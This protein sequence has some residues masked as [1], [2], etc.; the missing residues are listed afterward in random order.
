MRYALAL[1]VVLALL[2]CVLWVLALRE[3]EAVDAR[4]N[5]A[6]NTVVS[7]PVCPDEAFMAA[8]CGWD[9]PILGELGNDEFT[10]VA[11]RTILRRDPDP[12]H[13]SLDRGFTRYSMLGALMDSQEFR[14]RM[15]KETKP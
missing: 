5:R 15:L 2:F 6:E 7:V 12:K 8:T 14:E 10:R 1:T 4:L 11:Y 3:V 9:T 13:I